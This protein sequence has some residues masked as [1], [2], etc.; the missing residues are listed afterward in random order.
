MTNS[1]TE[2]AVETPVVEI[3]KEI[4]E[5]LLTQNPSVREAYIDAEVKAKLVSR[6]ETVKKAIVEIATQ[7]KELQK[8]KPDLVSYGTDGK[9]AQEFFS[10]EAVD[11]RGKASERIQKIEKALT[12]AFDTADYSDLENLV[13]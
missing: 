4:K 13:K 5:R 7:Q 12:K 6:T 1:E 9:V 8:L 2:T 10:K 3:Q 11:K